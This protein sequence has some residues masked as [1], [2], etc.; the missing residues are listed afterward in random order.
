[1]AAWRARFLVDLLALTEGHDE[2]GAPALFTAAATSTDAT[3]PKIH[4]NRHADESG[5]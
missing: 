2:L 5:K 1:M 3:E 4:T